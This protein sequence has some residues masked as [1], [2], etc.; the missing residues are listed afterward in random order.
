MQA[1]VDAARR[2]VDQGSSREQVEGRGGRRREAGGW[3]R[4]GQ[5]SQPINGHDPCMRHHSAACCAQVLKQLRAHAMHTHTLRS[6]HIAAHTAPSRL[7]CVRACVCACMC[8]CATKQESEERC[9]ALQQ[10]V[11][12]LQEGLAS[13]VQER[14]VRWRCVCG[15]EKGAGE[16]TPVTQMT[17]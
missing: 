3:G 13:M 2:A 1:E 16:L 4:A 11:E 14:E 5:S 7:C 6:V 15:R 8:E 12:G 17:W 9:S 10:Q